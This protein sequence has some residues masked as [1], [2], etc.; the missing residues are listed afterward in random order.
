MRSSRGVYAT[1][2]LTALCTMLPLPSVAD[3]WYAGGSLGQAFVDETI[4]GIDLDAD[5]TTLRV[6]A[7]YEFNDH[8]SLEASYLDLG[9]FRDSVDVAGTRVPIAA[10]ADGFSFAVLGR[11][12]LSD[13][14]AL[15]GKAGVFF[16]DGQS[17]VG[18]VIET[19]PS[20]QNAFFGV[21]VGYELADR[22]GVFLDL[23]HYDLDGA[24]P[25]L[26]SAGFQVRF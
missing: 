20:E 9:T 14:L 2:A 18:D 13:A 17:R 19:D 5:S 21:G 22:V 8:V 3:S 24:E 4:N 26:L 15:R 11:L 1:A 12:P 7:G 10:D 25:L 16:W 6:F 23:E